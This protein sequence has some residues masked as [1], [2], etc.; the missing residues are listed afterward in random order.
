ME[1][2]LE[3]LLLF[4]SCPMQIKKQMQRFQS[5]TA[6]IPKGERFFLLLL[7]LLLLLV[8]RLDILGRW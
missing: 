8:E 2:D 4:C 6:F 5:S 7:L 3:S 1:E